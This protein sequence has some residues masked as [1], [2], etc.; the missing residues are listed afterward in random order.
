[1]RHA[2]RRDG[3]KIGRKLAHHARLAQVA[4]DPQRPVV[5]AMRRGGGQLAGQRAAQRLAQRI[6]DGCDARGRSLHV[7]GAQGVVAFDGDRQQ[8]GGAFL[9]QRGPCGPDPP[10]DR[11]KGA[12]DARMAGEG[13]L[14][15]RSEDAHAVVRA[16][17]RRRQQERGLGQVGPA[18]DALHRRTV[19]RV[20]ADHH[21]QR[22]ALEQA[23]GEHVQL[24]ESEGRHGG[25][26]CGWHLNEGRRRT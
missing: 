7:D 3:G 18:R 9:P 16:R 8:P 4:D 5:D 15:A 23:R 22:V 21:G 6:V 12:A 26:Q 20:G 25:S 24:Q 14:L 10:H 17:L 2:N 11:R 1:V 13:Q 19:Q